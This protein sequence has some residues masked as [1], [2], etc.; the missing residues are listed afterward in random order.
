[1]T[2]DQ[3]IASLRASFG[4]LPSMNPSGRLYAGLCALLDR[5]DDD[6]LKAAH[7]ANIKFV[8]DLAFN[9]MIR[10]GLV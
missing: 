3:M 5:A 1:M 10:R 9:R 6:A 7:K 2:T 4:S 8:S